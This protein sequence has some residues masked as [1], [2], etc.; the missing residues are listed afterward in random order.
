M[1]SPFVLTT[2]HVIVRVFVPYDETFCQ[3]AGQIGGSWNSF[4]RVW[5]FPLDLQEQVKD[6]LLE[7]FNWTPPKEIR[8]TTPGVG[9]RR[10]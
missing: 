7:V 1:S 10:G 8:R 2:T 5:E 3:K 9:N 6:L 4:Q